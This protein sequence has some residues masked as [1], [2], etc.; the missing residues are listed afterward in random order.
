M[1]SF[2]KSPFFKS[3]KKGINSMKG[4]AKNT[5]FINPYPTYDKNVFFEKVKLHL[6]N[7]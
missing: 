1:H 7:R 5:N 6:P 2:A 3:K 4:K